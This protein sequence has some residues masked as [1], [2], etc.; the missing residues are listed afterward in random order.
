M[1][2]IINKAFYVFTNKPKNIILNKKGGL[3][4][5][6]M[7]GCN[8]WASNAGTEMWRN[9]DIET[10]DKDIKT[11][12]EHGVECMRVFPIWRDFQPIMPLYTANGD[13]VR[14]CLEGGKKLKN[15]YYLDEEMLG[16]FSAFLD[17]C[18]KYNMRLVVGVI[19]GW[20]SGGLFI[21]SALYGK[22]VIT[23]V[24]ARYF[25]KLY[26]KGFVKRFKNRKPIYA[27][28]L[29]NE[30]NCMGRVNDRIEAAS[31]TAEISNAIF[32]ADNSRPIVS[33]MHGLNI[34]KG[35]TI[36]DQAEFTDILTTHP[37]P[38]WCEHTRVDELLSYRTLMHPTAQTKY[39]AEI[40]K[41]PCLA[42]EIGNMGPM[43]CDDNNAANFLRVNLFSLW[44]NNAAGV[45]WWCAFD[46]EKLTT[47]PYTD[48]MGER[49]L[50]LLTSN[51]TPKPV[52]NEI[53][54][55][56]D[57]L[58]KVD[59]E[60]PKAFSRAVCLLTR[61]QDNWGAAYMTYNLLKK[62]GLNCD[63]E[64]ADNGIPDSPLYIMPSVMG[65][66]VLEKENYDEL[67]NKV[68]NGADLYISLDDTVFSQFESFAGLRVID[69]YGADNKNC[70]EFG[71]VRLE[72][73]RKMVF[74]FISTTAEI[75]AYDVDN[76]PIITVN[77]YGKGRVFVVNFP[78]ETNLLNRHNAF[79]V[80]DHIIYKNLF[81]D[82]ID[83]A[84]VKT[85]QEGITITC[86]PSTYGAVV[87]VINHTDS[88]KEIKPIIKDGYALDKVYYGDPQFVKPF[89]AS[90]FTIKNK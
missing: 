47:Y 31:W 87:T 56:S 25:E 4:M 80:N 29:G 66:N 23:D 46:Q 18:E 73:E 65:L 58:S 17:I 64:Y 27:W 76:N 21:P 51:H 24:T 9:F 48:Q 2:K 30:C 57:F 16:R 63:F 12:S 40:G 75:L 10:I 59:F 28:D 1:L 8:Y 89:D 11:L 43:L 69:S 42:E 84:L 35:W 33:G 45:M 14:Y 88:E 55:F 82:Y 41:K 60:L 78:L 61:G 90:V 22:N 83:A 74:K 85:E 68:Y 62:V 52:L 6:F 53:K 86:N 44:A 34:D 79:V 19:T 81:A 20:M 26:V 32:S 72:F 54:N 5:K 71:G 3:N 38:Y 13:V 70:F 49:E 36:S 77:K 50:G 39:Y 15:N 67:I 37:Y 7:L